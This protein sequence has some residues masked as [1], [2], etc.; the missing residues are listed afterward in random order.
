[1]IIDLYGREIEVVRRKGYW[2]VFIRGAEGKKRLAQ[3]ITIPS[4]VAE[5]ELV[6]Y[7]S[8]IYHEYATQRHPVVKHIG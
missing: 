1:M 2:M 4:D 6:E 7:L 8:D 5:A 3:D